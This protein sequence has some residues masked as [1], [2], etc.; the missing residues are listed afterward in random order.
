MLKWNTITT[1][2]VSGSL[3]LAYSWNSKTESQ[4]TNLWQKLTEARNMVVQCTARHSN[5]TV[6]CFA[7]LLLLI[8]FI[9]FRVRSHWT[10]TV[11]VNPDTGLPLLRPAINATV[12]CTKGTAI[13][14]F[15]NVIIIQNGVWINPETFAVGSCPRINI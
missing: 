4:G 1:T 11:A 6:L 14:S 13:I 3:H 15:S 2:A 8:L 10:V 5:G 9:L 12:A 7:L